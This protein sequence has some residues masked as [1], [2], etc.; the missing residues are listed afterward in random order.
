MHNEKEHL[1]NKIAYILG[2]YPFLTTTF[3]DREILAAKK[4]RVNI[5]L[6]AIRKPAPF[7]MNSEVLKLAKEIKYILPVS[8]FQFLCFFIY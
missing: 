8:W 6:I 7:E 1:K 3:I 5:I 2:T 4:R